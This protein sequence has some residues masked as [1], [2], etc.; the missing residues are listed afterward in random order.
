MGVMGALFKLMELVTFKLSP[1]RQQIGGE[2]VFETRQQSGFVLPC[3]DS[4][5]YNDHEVH[6]EQQG[7]ATP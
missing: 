2:R 7:F 1:K 4:F 3:H 5:Y 6:Q